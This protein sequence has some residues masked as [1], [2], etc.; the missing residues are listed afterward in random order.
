MPTVYAPHL[1]SLGIC[2]LQCFRVHLQKIRMATWLTILGAA[3]FIPVSSFECIGW[4][5]FNKG[6]WG[7]ES[8]LGIV[9]PDWTSQDFACTDHERGWNIRKNKRTQTYASYLLSCSGNACW[10][11]TKYLCASGADKAQV[12]ALFAV[13]KARSARK[14]QHPRA[15]PRPIP[16]YQTLAGTSAGETQM[17]TLLFV[18]MSSV[19]CRNALVHPKRLPK[20]VWI[21]QARNIIFPGVQCWCNSLSKLLIVRCM[22]F[23]AYRFF[24]SGRVL[25]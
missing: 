18:T 9:G 7:H 4:F 13:K 22:W 21:V 8:Q 23:H 3:G 25:L 24:P 20:T 19:H 5:W 6:H 1:A 2:E 12:A 15:K 10:N 14:G 11:A 17:F 16:H